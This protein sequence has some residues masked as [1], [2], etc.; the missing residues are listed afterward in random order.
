VIALP[1]AL[2][3]QFRAVLRRSLLDQ[4][5]RGSWP[6]VL[7]QADKNGLTLQA[8]Q[9]DRALRYHRDGVHPPESIAFRASMLAEFEGRRE[10]LVELE[11]IAFGKGRAR[12]KDGGV[13]RI[14][15][16]ETVVPDSV[17]PFP[18][19]PR[20]FTPM[21]AGF[22]QALDEAVKTTA[23]ESARFA[24]GRLQLRGKAG[25]IVATDGRQLLVQGGL[26]LPWTD[27]VLVPRLSV[28]GDLAGEGD[29]AVGRT[30]THMALKIGPWTF[31]LS[32]DT[33]S[34]FP[35][36]DAVIPSSKEK[37]TVLHL[38]ALD[39]LFLAANLPKLPGGD[40]DSSP[41]TLDLHDPIALRSQH[42][43]QGAS[44]L[45]LARSKI[46]GPPTRLCM[47]RHYLVRAVKLGFDQVEVL[48]KDR[49]VVCRD[50]S[51][52]YLW[53]PLDHTTAL[54]PAADTHRIHSTEGSPS[55]ITIKPERRKR[56]MRTPQTNGQ[57]ES[58]STNG[59][60]EP[61]RWGIAEVIA[62]TETLR[63]LLQDASVRSA[64][65]LAALKHQRRR[66]RAVQQAMRSL[67][68]LQLDQ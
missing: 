22:L 52:V 55:P 10:D 18:D 31:L 7:C 35:D 33:Q 28:T 61:E 45:V 39:A 50:G 43:K 16:L 36:V 4:E 8:C 49:P 63:G 5:P 1:R 21:P 65:L 34:R 44:E 17:P 51:R 46:T 27:T 54:S 48:A 3:R 26:A 12:W 30:K 32:I 57:P 38:D 13:P 58:G 37:V 40:E 67:K 19:L 9:G 53:M 14:I 60:T 25:E 59:T 68:E 23:R 66:S 64:R 42:E 11:Q 56:L 15:D 6:L 41:V 47:N 24:L 2:V 20:Q 62:E 29:V